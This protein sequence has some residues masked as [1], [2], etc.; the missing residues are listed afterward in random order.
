MCNITLQQG[1]NTT[2]AMWAFADLN[3]SARLQLVRD[4]F[5]AGQMECSLRRH[6][7]SVGPGTPIRDIVNRCRVWRVM[8][9]T[10]TVG[11]LRPARNDLG[12]VG[13]VNATVIADAGS[14]IFEGDCLPFGP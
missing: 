13:F 5:I 9:K 6:L 4:I 14:V 8:Q 1:T 10:R 2:L 11:K 3:A 7:Y 12:R